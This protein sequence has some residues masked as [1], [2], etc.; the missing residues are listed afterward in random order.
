MSR[1]TVFTC[2]RC[3]AAFDEWYA[4]IR[5]QT[6]TVEL[7]RPCGTELRDWCRGPIGPIEV[8]LDG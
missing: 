7:C 8:E 5:F 3:R 1:R 2:D 4:D 6:Q